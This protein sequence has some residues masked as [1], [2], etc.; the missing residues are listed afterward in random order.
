MKCIFTYNN[1]QINPVIIEHQ[2]AVL[3][4]LNIFT[5]IEH[6]HLFYNAK[7]GDVVPDQ[8][9][10]H[11]LPVLFY[12]KGYSSVLILDVDCI[13]LSSN[14]LDYTF[15]QCES[16]KLIGN[17]QRSNHL[18]N[19]KHLYCGASCVAIS[20]NTW[21]KIGR[22][23]SAP[24]NRSDICE[25]YAWLSSQNNVDIEF[26]TPLEY[27]RLPYNEPNP[28]P[29]DD[30]LPPYGIGTTFG[31]NKNEPMFYHLFQS[32]LNLH[33]ELFINKCNSLLNDPNRT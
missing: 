9:I 4:K 2:K 8:V 19:N 23:S 1:F 7:D 6:E 10:D 26:F 16:G 31:N 17:V 24:T 3:N 27:E 22:P 13:P 21:E 18:N 29:L 28:W 5:D 11:A 33:V 30:I 12:E 32:R 20:R 25:E 15:N 14:A